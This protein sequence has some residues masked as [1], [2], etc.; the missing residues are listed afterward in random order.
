MLSKPLLE[1]I[2]AKHMR[3]LGELG[4]ATNHMHLANLANEL[5]GKL[6]LPE[7]LFRADF[8][9]IATSFGAHGHQ[10]AK[11]AQTGS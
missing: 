1:T 4:T 8:H 6:L 11:H 5:V 10:V 3:A 7:K 9:S 2:T